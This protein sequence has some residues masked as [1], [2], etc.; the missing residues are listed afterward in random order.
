MGTVSHVLSPKPSL[1][2]ETGMNIEFM[3]YVMLGSD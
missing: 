3:L 1:F 2:F